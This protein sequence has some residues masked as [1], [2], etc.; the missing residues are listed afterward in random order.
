MH[1]IT[2]DDSYCFA[3]EGEVYAIYLRNGGTTELNLESFNSELDIKWYDPRN[4]G[5][6][7]EGNIK[8]IQGPGRVNI[9]IAPGDIEK[10]WA[11]LI[12][13]INN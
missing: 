2:T 11:I 13:K 7:I 10:D 5:E 6:L 3:K 4:G 1:L 8:T 9:G 12:R